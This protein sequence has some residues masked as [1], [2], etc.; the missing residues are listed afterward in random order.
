MRKIIYILLLSF[1]S[2]SL[3]NETIGR[4]EKKEFLR[5]LEMEENANRERI[6]ENIIFCKTTDTLLVGCTELYRVFDEIRNNPKYE[7]TDYKKIITNIILYEEQF[8]CDDPIL[9]MCFSLNDTITQSYNKETFETFLSMYADEN[10]HNDSVYRIKSFEM[11]EN[12]F[13]TVLYYLYHNG[14]YSYVDGYSG[15]CFC[16]KID[17]FY[18][19]WLDVDI[20]E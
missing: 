4:K 1:I 3:S 8:E 12:S 6:N 5:V 9:S 2:C 19:R 16:R 18:L 11:T 17:D 15:Y 10:F 14:Y 20:F 13:Y 7:R